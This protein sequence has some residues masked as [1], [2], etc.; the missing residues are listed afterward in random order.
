MRNL[1]KANIYPSMK[2]I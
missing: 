2:F 1:N